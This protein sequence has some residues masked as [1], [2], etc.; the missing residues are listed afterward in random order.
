MLST[1]I[2]ALLLLASGCEGLPTYETPLSG[3][4]S[5]L[6]NITRDGLEYPR[7]EHAAVLVGDNIYVLGGILPWNGREYATTNIVQKYNMITGIWTETASMP[8]ALNHA[9][10]AVVDDKIYC[11]GGLE[12]LDET[13][14]NAT[15][16]SAVYDPTT[17]K[18]SVLPSMPEGREIGSAATLVV[19]DTIYLPGGLAYTNITYDQEGTVS[20]FTSYNVRTQEWEILPDLPAPRDHAGK[21]IYQDM[22]YILG[23]RAFGNKN[24]VS[25]VFGFNITSHQW[26]TAYEPMPIAR[27]G[28]ASASIGSQMF[29]AGGEGDRSTPTAVFPEMQAYDASK[30]TWINY[31]DMPLPIH[32]SDAVVYRGEIVIPG[33]GIVTGATL[34]PVVQT[35][36]PPIQDLGEQGMSTMVMIYQVIIDLPWM[37]LTRR[38]LVWMS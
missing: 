11:L 28:V 22:L 9:N 21:G 7:Q 12:A 38:W 5:T 4:W 3:R 1:A 35:F 36:K 32:G 18:W 30:N 10:V 6:P 13:Y 31:A 23:G 29:T 37:L 14:W 8:A 33:G 25:T 15:G 26:S 17:D 2:T 27:G 16:R 20:R 19:D 34:T 24:V